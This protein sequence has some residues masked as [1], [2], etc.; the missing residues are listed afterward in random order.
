MQLSFQIKATCEREMARQSAFFLVPDD[1]YCHSRQQ[2]MCPPL[3][4]AAGPAG[5]ALILLFGKSFLIFNGG[6]HC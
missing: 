4:H 2:N 5:R 6:E 1:G 3:Y